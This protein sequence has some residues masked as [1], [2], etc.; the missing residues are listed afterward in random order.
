M[1]IIRNGEITTLHVNED[2]LAAII[3]SLAD[4]LVGGNEILSTLLCIG[5]TKASLNALK[6]MLEKVY[7]KRKEPEIKT[8]GNMLLTIKA[9][10]ESNKNPDGTTN[11]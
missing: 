2:E 8:I 5:I 7:E 10:I 9:G 3:A 6:T 11:Q 4:E 1:I